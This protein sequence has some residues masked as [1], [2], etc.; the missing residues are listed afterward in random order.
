MTYR[1]L[2]DAEAAALEARGCFCPDWRRIEVSADFIP[3]NIRH[4]RFEG[5]VRLGGRLD[6]ALSLPGEASRP[7]GLYSSYLK[8]CEI[9]GPVYI[10]RA[11]RLEGYIIEADVIIENVSSLVVEGPTAFGNGVEI[12][13]LNEGGGREALLFDQLT[14]QIAYLMASY[15]HEP[16]MVARLKG[17]IRKYCDSQRSDK[18]LIRTGACI[19]DVRSVRNVN[20]GP[21]ARVNGA[22]LLEEGAVASCA[23]APAFVGEGVIARKFII[24]S[25][26]SVDSG[27]I[28][29]KCFVGQGV[30]IGK[31]FS[32]ENSLF[33]A[34]C[35]GFHGEAVSL[36]AGPYT[37]SHHKSS[38]LIAGM[39]SFFN[40]GSG[41][42]QS[43]HMYKLGPVHQGLLER[44]CKTGSFS[45]LLWPCRIGAFSVVMDKHGANFDTSDLPFSYLTVEEGKSTL[46]PAMNLF[47]VG[48][49]RDSEKWPARDR[50]KGP[51]KLDLIHFEL[52]SPYTAGKMIRG[53]AIL[54]ALYDEAPKEQKYVKYQG[55]Y[56]LRLLLK[57]G[58]KYY[59]LALKKYY[60]EQ[61]VKRLEG[62]PPDSLPDLRKILHSGQNGTGEWVDVAGL[63]APAAVLREIVED[64]KNG[65]FESIEQLRGRL[66]GAY[67][68]YETYAWNWYAHTL[69]K[70][71]GIPI[72][73]ATQEQLAGLIR[74]W[75]ANALKLNNMI[76]KDAEKEFDQ[77]SRIGFGADG[78]EEVQKTDFS[79]VRGTY[80]DNAF[81]RRLRAENEE[82][83]RKA[84]FWVEELD[85]LFHSA[86]S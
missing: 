22:Q 19:R 7:A 60:G 50:R 15:R 8:N 56:I 12:E 2:T 43:N 46:T 64:L 81:V 69:E 20:F 13:V 34:N 38:L 25:G 42:N 54:Q 31:Q 62:N 45:Y 79:A 51:D 1:S 71:M 70:E 75:Q 61:L 9:Q 53:S 30:R 26:A 47:T 68:N 18:G 14:A 17:L 77:N 86:V 83:G 72:G 74:E 78:D 36:F 44:G 3:D 57:A 39:F 32:A 82:T 52:L 37:V 16:E 49:K 80:E 63:L 55:I 5:Q 6:G 66:K 41:T 76:L 33:F 59:Q 10:S 35:E 48:T 29:D 28:L 65:R 23:E 11:G 27:A 21:H 4:V 67:D 40:A 85:R 24:H 84:A 73:Q 58:R